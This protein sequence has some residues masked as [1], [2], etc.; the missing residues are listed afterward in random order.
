MRKFILVVA[1][2]AVAVL[3]GKVLGQNSAVAQ[4]DAGADILTAINLTSDANLHFG[5]MTVSTT[6]A[7]VQVTAAET[8]VRS[9]A[10][11][12]V[13]LLTQGTPHAAAHF[14]IEDA[15]PNATYTITLPSA[16]VEIE[17]ENENKMDITG[18]THSIVGT[19]TLDG[20]GDGGFYVGAILNIGESQ[21][22]GSYTGSFDVTVAY[23]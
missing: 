10:S 12:T 16:A 19:P 6:A 5:S 4:A 1:I 20:S 7:T 13:V 14:K 15:E 22:S 3:P 21:P 23:N 9:V 2:A 11:G 17:N 8:A 18:F